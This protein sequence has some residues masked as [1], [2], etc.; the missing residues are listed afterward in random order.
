MTS[1]LRSQN[2]NQSISP[3]PDHRQFITPP[4]PI[5]RTS[6]PHHCITGGKVSRFSVPSYVTPPLISGRNGAMGA[7]FTSRG[8]WST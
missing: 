2:F 7:E 8:Y 6:A 4:P 1:I 5:T 3:S